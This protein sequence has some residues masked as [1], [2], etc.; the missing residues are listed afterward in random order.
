MA[1]IEAGESIGE[2]EQIM[3]LEAR[4]VPNSPRVLTGIVDGEALLLNLATGTY[5]N[6]VNVAGYI[7][8]QIETQHSIKEMVEGLIQR[9]DVSVERARRD[10]DSF[11][12]KLQKEHLVLATS[13]PAAV[14]ASVVAAS[15]EYLP[16]ESPEL[17]RIE[18]P[19]WKPLAS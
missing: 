2:W 19:D 13:L 4:F 18:Q 12:Q 15:A 16:Y 11:L 17:E 14:A 5:Y 1:G 9:Y 8:S 10:L 7:W 6:M 3:T